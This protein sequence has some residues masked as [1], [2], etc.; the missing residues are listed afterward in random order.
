VG[1][2]DGEKGMKT[3]DNGVFEYEVKDDYHQSRRIPKEQVVSVSPSMDDGRS[4]WVV[5]RRDFS[6]IATCYDRQDALDIA[7]FFAERAKEKQ[8]DSDIPPVASWKDAKLYHLG[9]QDHPFF[10]NTGRL[11]G[12]MWFK[13][14]LSCIHSCGYDPESVRNMLLAF[15]KH[16][17]NGMKGIKTRGPLENIELDPLFA[18]MLTDVPDCIGKVADYKVKVD[19]NAE[20]NT[21]K[22]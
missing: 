21:V 2:T 10:P 1:K 6:I 3:H 11:L 22:G 16:I 17:D 7:A 20:P 15:A 14:W 12:K 4:C 9:I 19:P 8:A 13:G 5:A 18:K